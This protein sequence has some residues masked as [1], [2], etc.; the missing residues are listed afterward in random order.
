MLLVALSHNAPNL[1]LFSVPSKSYLCAPLSIHVEFCPPYGPE[2]PATI[3]GE[4]TL[5]LTY[6]SIQIFYSGF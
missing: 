2:N 5:N 3:E 4:P 1:C 6:C